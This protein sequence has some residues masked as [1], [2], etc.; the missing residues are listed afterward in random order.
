[1]ESSSLASYFSSE[2]SKL[3]LSRE[4]ISEL[5]TDYQKNKNQDSKNKLVVH[6]LPF[7]VSQAKKYL[8]R[9][10]LS[11][12]LIKDYIHEGVLGLIHSLDLYDSSK[13]IGLLSYSGD[14]INYYMQSYH[15]AQQLVHIP[16][17]R[18]L[19]GKETSIGGIKLSEI[20]RRGR[21]S[22]YALDNSEEKPSFKIPFLRE[23]T[24]YKLHES[25]LTGLVLSGLDDF[26]RTV[27]VLYYGLGGESSRSLRD[28]SKELRKRRF[29]GQGNFS[30]EGIS[31]E[32]VN[33]VLKRSR[34]KIEMNL[35][36]KNISLED[37]VWDFF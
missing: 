24:R 21:L 8:R 35:M 2:Y 17:E 25:H 15:N 3:R 7:I 36:R 34:D 5:I 26:E 32:N 4:Q 1:M 22:I 10:N 28:V 18:K 31:H 19:R 16:N 6:N 14:W 13:G 11:R 30:S 37:V 9:H 12:N 23:T 20:R 27:V 33:K 29:S